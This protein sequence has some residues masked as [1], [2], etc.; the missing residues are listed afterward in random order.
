LPSSAT[1]AGRLDLQRNVDAATAYGWSPLKAATDG[2]FRLILAPKSELYDLTA[3]PGETTNLYSS[4]PE[5][6]RRL[7]QSI[8]SVQKRERTAPRP[9]V[10]EAEAAELAQ[11]PP[12]SRYLSG[13]SPR[14]G[15][16]DPKDGIAMLSEFERARD[17]IRQRRARAR[18]RDCCASW[19]AGARGTCRS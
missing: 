12:E 7:A 14:S 1:R 16:I 11:S 18:G 4:R 8:A 13:S 9:K 3:D 19:C 10:S 2:R 17:E 15:T 5:D 6:A